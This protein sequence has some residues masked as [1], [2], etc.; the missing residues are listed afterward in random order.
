MPSQKKS[1]K[2][3]KV[4]DAKSVIQRKTQCANMV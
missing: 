2:L 4:T 1:Y 3:R